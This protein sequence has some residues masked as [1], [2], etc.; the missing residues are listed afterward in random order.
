MVGAAV[1]VSVECYSGHIYAQRP[2][3]FVWDEQRHKIERILEQWRSP[4][5]PGFRVV[6][7]DG[8]QVELNYHEMNDEWS[9]QL[10]P[11]PPLHVG[12]PVDVMPADKR[13]RKE[14]QVDA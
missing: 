8:V 4:D 10:L 3:A 12:T 5:G 1:T 9:L 2:T 6:T 7:T 11:D 13:D 14:N